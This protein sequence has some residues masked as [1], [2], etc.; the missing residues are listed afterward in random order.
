[1][2]ILNSRN[3]LGLVVFSLAIVGLSFSASAQNNNAS[4]N[5]KNRPSKEEVAEKK[6]EKV[7]DRIT[8]GYSKL[9]QKMVE[10]ENR[11][12]TREEERK[13]EFDEKE[14]A[15]RTRLT[16]RRSEIDANFA[17]HIEKMIQAAGDDA[18]KKT[19]VAAFQL[20]VRN[21][22]ETRR[23][24][25]D[26]A[27][28]TYRNQVETAVRERKTALDSPLAVFRSETK[29]AYEKAAASCE[30]GEEIASVRT[31]LQTNLK[32]AREKFQAQ[33]QNR[34]RV[35]T[36]L[37]SEISVRNQAIQKANDDLKA[38][39]TKAKEAFQN[40]FTSTNSEEV[41]GAE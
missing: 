31:T 30:A 12:R 40:A 8:S 6:T 16:E 39:L 28:E 22:M 27:R 17:A 38:A 3:I 35:R 21:A 41:S 11:I 25:V 37:E 34:E 23:T 26:A 14:E 29:A 10:S 2:K 20:A 32:N 9:E 4:E 13:S 24:A 36:N 15:L 18:V 5:A 7:C 19:A 33:N 1:M